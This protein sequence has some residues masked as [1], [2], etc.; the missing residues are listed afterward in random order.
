MKQGLLQ[1]AE[2]LS[3]LSVVTLWM[4]QCND[5]GMGKHLLVIFYVNK[6][7]LID[8]IHKILYLELCFLKVEQ[9]VDKV[10]KSGHIVMSSSTTSY[11]RFSY[12]ATSALTLIRLGYLMS[13]R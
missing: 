12:L 8:I 13:L 6:Y 5:A 7:S 9:V 4:N 11:C 3:H 1:T 10:L 2:S